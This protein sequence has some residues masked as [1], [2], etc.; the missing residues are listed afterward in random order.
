MPAMI[1]L[2]SANA[3]S[4]ST[5]SPGFTGSRAC[6]RITATACPSS[7]RPYA[8]AVAHGRNGIACGRVRQ[9]QSLNTS[10]GDPLAKASAFFD[11]S[12]TPTNAVYSAWG[13]PG[14]TERGRGPEC[15]HCPASRCGAPTVL[16]TPACV[17]SERP[18]ARAG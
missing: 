3:D 6:S 17:R 15:V 18:A 13:R 7:T 16:A 2:A 12:D 5:S 8:G 1:A 11:P 10:W 9:E 4:K 14:H